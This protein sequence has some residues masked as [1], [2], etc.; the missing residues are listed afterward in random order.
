VP[1][2]EPNRPTRLPASRR[3]CQ[4]KAIGDLSTFG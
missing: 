2:H 3:K 4:Q 1:G